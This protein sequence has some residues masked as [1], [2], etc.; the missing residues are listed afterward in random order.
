MQISATAARL[1]AA[2]LDEDRHAKRIGCVT[3][4]IYMI[5]SNGDP[6]TLAKCSARYERLYTKFVLY[7]HVLF[8]FIF[9]FY[10]KV[11]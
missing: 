6:D 1:T 2:R 7:L 9:Y 11:P 3:D 8:I 4:E 10:F 5:D